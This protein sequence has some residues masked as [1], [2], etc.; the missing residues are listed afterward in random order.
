MTLTYSTEQQL[1]AMAAA[2]GL[3]LIRRW[4]DWTGAPATPS[5]TDPV[6]VYRR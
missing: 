3:R 5:S 4:H 1:D 2:A 6:S